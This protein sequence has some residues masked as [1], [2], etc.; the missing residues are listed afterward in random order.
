MLPWSRG[1]E[2][3]FRGSPSQLEL[4]S[5]SDPLLSISSPS[6]AYKEL[7]STN[8][9]FI[10]SHIEERTPSGTVDGTSCSMDYPSDFV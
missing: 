3:P 5:S 8:T 6:V 10:K 1:D 7:S 2:N 4:L 9:L